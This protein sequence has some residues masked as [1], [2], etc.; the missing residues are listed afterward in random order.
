[1]SSRCSSRSDQCGVQNTCMFL[2][3]GHHRFVR[4]CASYVNAVLGQQMYVG[5][6]LVNMQKIEICTPATVLNVRRFYLSAFRQGVDTAMNILRRIR[7]GIYCVRAPVLHTVLESFLSCECGQLRHET[8]GYI[9]DVHVFLLVADTIRCVCKCI[10]RC[11]STS[12][13]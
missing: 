3:V 4:T 11:L 5:T 6:M 10:G 7:F 13:A 1:M 12:H 2:K 8:E 9:W